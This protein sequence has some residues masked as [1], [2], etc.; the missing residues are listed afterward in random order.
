M[1]S[2]MT[3]DTKN[4]VAYQNT[5]LTADGMAYIEM[6]YEDYLQ[7]KS[8]VGEDWQ[9]YFAQYEQTGDAP[10]NAIKEQFLLLARNRTRPAAQVNSTGEC[11]P[12]QMA[13]Q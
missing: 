7:D 8:S 10:H 13:V 2:I 1:A 4:A 6:L 9:Q 12:K 11:N 3:K 5:E